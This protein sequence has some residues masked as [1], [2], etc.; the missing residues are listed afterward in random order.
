MESSGEVPCNIISSLC[1]VLKPLDSHAAVAALAQCLESTANEIAPDETDDW[2]LIELLKPLHTLRCVLDAFELAVVGQI[3]NRSCTVDYSGLNTAAHLGHVRRQ[4]SSTA[5]QCVSTA[6]TATRYQQ[7][8]TALGHGAVTIDHLRVLGSV[9]NHRNASDLVEIE[10]ALLSLAEI[11]P[12]TQWEQEIR[13]IASLIDADGAEPKEP[14]PDRLRV[15][16]HHNATV[17]IDGTFNSIEGTSLR[18]M[19]QRQVERSFARLI[20]QRHHDANSTDP[21]ECDRVCGPLP[22]HP[23]ML[24]QALIELVRAGH[25]AITTNTKTRQPETDLTVVSTPHP[26]A[27]LFDD[28]GLS[29]RYQQQL[30]INMFGV[31]LDPFTLQ[32]RITPSNIVRVL[33]DS[34]GNP[35]HVTK[36][37]RYATTEQRKALIARGGHT[38]VFP[39]CQ[40]HIEFGHAHHIVEYA[41]D[42]QT[43][44]PN[45]VMLCPGHHRLTHSPG[46]SLTASPQGQLEWTTPHGTN[47]TALPQHGKHPPP[48]YRQTG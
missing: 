34:N 12:F 7:F 20:E 48:P 45:L 27:T 16:Q 4:R 13:S 6:R 15:T 36:R 5:K 40:R 9:T 31:Q 10:S 43:H 44:L 8:V 11:L 24:A 35:T 28:L 21:I 29:G 33:M 23:Q 17:Q 37:R 46:W 1:Q 2:L 3:D 14:T 30:F 41:N 42:G 39:G 22:S 26:D 19:L 32:S 38:C 47:V 18:E 25:V